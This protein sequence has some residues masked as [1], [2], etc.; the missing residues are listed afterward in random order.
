MNPMSYNVF[1]K[2]A[3]PTFRTLFEMIN[4]DEDNSNFGPL[5]AMICA[6]TAADLSQDSEA[7]PLLSVAQRID[8]HAGTLEEAVNI[9]GRLLTIGTDL[10]TEDVYNSMSAATEVLG[11]VTIDQIEELHALGFFNDYA[12]RTS[13]SD[14]WHGMIARAWLKDQELGELLERG[15]RIY[16]NFGN[17]VRSSFDGDTVT[18]TWG[19]G[20][21]QPSE[22]FSSEEFARITGLTLNE[23][24]FAVNASAAGEQVDQ[25]IVDRMILTP[26]LLSRNNEQPFNADRIVSELEK[27]SDDVF[28]QVFSGHWRMTVE[29]KK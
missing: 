22:T 24:R 11:Y 8:N 20:N 7:L 17:G 1:L 18:F 27:G 5:C 28:W 23:I 25:N 3:T 12:T 21:H 9:A 14:Y 2:P 10:N 6:L 26:K 19:Y 13:C 16:E 4:H 15:Y 29:E